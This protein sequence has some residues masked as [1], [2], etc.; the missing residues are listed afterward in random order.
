MKR[1]R[2]KSEMKR[3]EKNENRKLNDKTNEIFTFS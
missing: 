3:D 2:R 1:R